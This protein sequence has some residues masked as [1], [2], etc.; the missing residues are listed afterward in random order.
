MHPTPVSAKQHS[1]FDLVRSFD[2]LLGTST[3]Q[4]DTTPEFVS[5]I[6]SS[7]LYQV[8]RAEQIPIRQVTISLPQ[9]ETKP[10][11]TKQK[12]TSPP[13]T[14]KQPLPRKPKQQKKADKAAQAQLY[15][16]HVQKWQNPNHIE[17]PP[18]YSICRSQP[19]TAALLL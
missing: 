2:H 8:R 10:L 12:P 19:T 5:N 9:Q 3:N 7:I 4:F 18:S 15:A 16:Q 13:P 6:F 11:G 14:K 1:L 17:P